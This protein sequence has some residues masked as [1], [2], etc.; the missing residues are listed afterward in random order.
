MFLQVGTGE[1]LYG[2]EMEFCITEGFTRG[3]VGASMIEGVMM[4]YM[5]L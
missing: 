3:W 1:D 2:P 5:G 4:H